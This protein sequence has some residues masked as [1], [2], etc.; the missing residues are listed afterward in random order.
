MHLFLYTMYNVK[1]WYLLWWDNLSV[2]FFIRQFALTRFCASVSAGVCQCPINVSLQLLYIIAAIITVRTAEKTLSQRTTE[3]PPSCFIGCL[4]LCG[5][6]FR[7]FPTRLSVVALTLQVLIILNL[8]LCASGNYNNNNSHK[9]L[10]K[11]Q[12]CAGNDTEISK[13]KQTSELHRV[14]KKTAP[15]NMSK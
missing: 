5:L 14:R 8:R 9:T 2:C 3:K 13:P 11:C 12:Q 1:K 10:L 6:I 4:W 7:H 15:V